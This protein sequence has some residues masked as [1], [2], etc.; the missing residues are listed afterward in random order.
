M[1][2]FVAGTRQGYDVRITK[3][4][5]LVAL[6]AIV[7]LARIVATVP[8]F[9]QT[10]DEPVHIAGGFDW[11]TAPG[12]DL[13]PEHPPLARVAFA[14]DAWLHGARIA[15]QI[16]TRAERG[17]ALLYRD[18]RY[19]RN[20]AGARAGNLP[21]FLI[22]FAAVGLWTR[23]LFGDATAVVAMALFGALPPILGLAGLA[24]TDMAPAAMVAMSLYLL[25]LW[26][27]RP[28]RVRT[29]LLALAVGLGLLTKFSF[30]VYFPIAA[31]VL[32]AFR[33]VR[34]PRD[35]FAVI[36]IA[37]LIVWAGYKFDVGTIADARLRTYPPNVYVEPGLFSNLPLPAPYFFVGIE[38][39]QWHSRQ[40][41][42]SF[43]LG[44]MSTNGWW[45]YFPVVW[46]FKTPLPFV[47]LTLA[48]IALLL[49]R[50]R[51]GEIAGVTIAP[52]VMLIPAMMSGIDIGIR[53]I[54]PLYPLLT[55]SVA[56]VG[57]ELWQRRR[58]FALVA[59]VWFAAETTLAHPD[60]LAWFNEAA[61]T[62][63][64]RI[65]NDSNL[66]WGQDLLRLANVANGEQ[67][68]PLYVD[69]FGSADP[70]RHIARFEVLRPNTPVHGW[71]AMSEMMLALDHD[72]LRWLD[73]YRPV[74]RIGRSI[75][76]YRIAP[77]P[78]SPPPSGHVQTR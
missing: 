14:I 49:R 16:G 4:V 47:G 44:R 13:D 69:Y 46:F 32:L 71:V 51:S 78:S 72:E 20:L 62:H 50:R 73:A 56:S 65:A 42:P 7:P 22:A 60:Y 35:V 19:V 10:V 55:I 25:M 38:Y 30:V 68:A 70:R 54:L 43:L 63:P 24:T 31:L 61:G 58:G 41:H 11:L 27:D 77:A 74:R 9:S 26:L 12:Y 75:R 67:L 53:H 59:I 33:R 40:G 18:A 37:S 57:M 66:D 28:S 29:L 6:L 3:R 8:V 36:A 48:G 23:R 39:V 34:P 15:P 52:L 17:N 1:V 5:A 76:L 64:E 2:S 45:Y 21:F